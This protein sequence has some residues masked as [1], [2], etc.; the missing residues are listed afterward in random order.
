M[1]ARCLYAGE[2]FGFKI[3]ILSTVHDP[4]LVLTTYPGKIERLN[5]R[6]DQR[7]ECVLPT[8]VKVRENEC[9]SVLV[10]LSYRGC[11]VK[12]KDQGGDKLPSFV[13]DD[14][15]MVCTNLP[16]KEEA[17]C[18]LGEIRNIDRTADGIQVGI[19]F[20]DRSQQAA[21]QWQAFIDYIIELV[22]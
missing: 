13:R 14:P 11:R 9:R 2:A 17:V 5:L 15:I 4:P 16:G 8:I 1:I 18:L 10:D 7:H 22:R 6:S 3:N 12:I 19:Q 20:A 21:D